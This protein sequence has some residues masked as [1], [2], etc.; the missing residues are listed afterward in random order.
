MKMGN[1]ED[2]QD[3]GM[4]MGSRYSLFLPKIWFAVSSVGIVPFGKEEKIVR[5]KCCRTI[6]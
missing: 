6:F 4:V 1:E 5:A 3:A 2:E